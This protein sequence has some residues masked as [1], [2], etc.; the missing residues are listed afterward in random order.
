M[1]T[2]KVPSMPAEYTELKVQILKI[3][4]MGLKINFKFSVI[5]STT[6]V[7]LDMH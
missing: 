6:T 7:I 3:A 2:S 5:A 1:T 4:H